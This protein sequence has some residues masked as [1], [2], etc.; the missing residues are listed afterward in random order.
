MRPV[1]RTALTALAFFALSTPV[2]AQDLFGDD[3]FAFVAF[4]DL[5]YIRGDVTEDHYLRLI[6][7]VNAA[8]PVF[9]I[10]VGDIKGGGSQCSDERFARELEL[11]NSFD[12]A[13]IYTPGDNEWTDCHRA[14]AGRYDPLERLA[15]L[16]SMFFTDSRSLGRA[17]IELVRQPDV[18]DHDTLI[19]NALWDHGG[20]T[21]ATVHVVGSNNNF[22]TRESSATDEF[23]ARDA[24]NIAWIGAA[25]DRAKAENSAALVL[26]LHADPFEVAGRHSGFTRTINA[27]S[28]GAESFGKPVMVIHGDSHK[29]I[30]DQ[31]FTNSDGERLDTVTRLEVFGARDVHAV[32]VIVDPESPGI[33]TYQPLLVPGNLRAGASG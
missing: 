31:P 4:G 11:M 2:Q 19:E 25:F 15:K 16:R 1:N 9:S 7:T 33:F 20:V 13:L 14:N 17:P 27:I 28:S 12:T 18:S 26:A 3:A 6:D 29:F 21:F 10:H 22:E 5:P 32:R 23:F 8:G 30:V 24:G